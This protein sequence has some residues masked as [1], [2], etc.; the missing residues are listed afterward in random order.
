MAEVV[1]TGCLRKAL[2]RHNPDP[3]FR[4]A[5][6]SV[7]QGAADGKTL[8]HCGEPPPAPGTLSRE[9]LSRSPA[10]TGQSVVISARLID[11]EDVDANDWLAVNQFTVIEQ[12]HN[13][14]PDVALFV[15]GLPLAVMEL[16]NPGDENATLEGAYNQ[17]QTYK[18]QIPSLFRTNAVLVTSD[19]LHARVGALTSNI[20]R[21]M[22]WRD[23]W[24]DAPSRRRAHLSL[25]RSSKG[26]S[27]RAAS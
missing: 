14:R 20:E 8:A 9:W 11:F 26:C 23:R 10:R 4:N 1:L 25:E 3:P 2:E 22:P 13:R 15:N 19:G 12:D 7:T 17:L 5:R 21:F 6:G 18:D 24:T 27:R 16:K